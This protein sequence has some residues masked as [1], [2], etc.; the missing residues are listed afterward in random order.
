[1]ERI[2]EIASLEL[3]SLKEQ[4]ELSTY[5]SRWK[6]YQSLSLIIFVLTFVAPPIVYLTVKTTFAGEMVIKALADN[7]DKI[8]GEQKR[9]K[10]LLLKLLPPTIAM[11]FIENHKFSVLYDATTIMFCSIHGFNEQCVTDYSAVQVTIKK[12]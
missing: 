1:M 8:A 2:R 6:L 9:N 10:T 5:N 12:Q 3:Q 7:S 11:K 4:A